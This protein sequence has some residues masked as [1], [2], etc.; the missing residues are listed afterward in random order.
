MKKLVLLFIINCC[1]QISASAQCGQ[2]GIDSGVCYNSTDGLQAIAVD[3][4]I[5]TDIIV[6]DFTAGSIETCCDEIVV[7]SGALGSGTGG[8]Q[9]YNASQ[10]SG[11]F[12]GLSFTAAAP[13]E[14]LSIYVNADGSVDCTTE[15]SI[16]PVYNTSCIGCGL[17]GV[18]SGVCYNSTDGLQAIAV[19]IGS[20]TD[21][22]VVDF[23]AGS[24]ETCC[25]EI[26]VYSG[27]LGSGT[28]GTQ[29]HNASQGSGTFAGL[30]FT[31]AAPGEYLSIY[32]NADGSVDCTT[33]G[34]ISPVYNTSC[35]IPSIGCGLTGVDS[36]VCYN[37]TD[38]LQPIAINIG[39]STD[40]ITVNFTA[41]SIETCCDE[42][43]VY[44]GPLGSGTGGTQ[45]HNASQASGTFAGLSFTA[46]APGEY[47][48]I[49]VN[50][51]GSVDCTTEG[52]VSPVYNT[53]CPTL[54]ID[55]V[56]FDTSSLTIYPNP[57]SNFVTLKNP[58]NIKLKNISIHDLTGRLVKTLDAT[59]VTD[60]L[61]IDLS[62]LSSNIYFLS[63]ETE[64]NKITFK[65]IKE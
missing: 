14:Y 16:S 15:G 17:T 21:I 27:P 31:A 35:I 64:K 20:P 62:D 63:A 34:N 2:T 58:E 24:I 11:T 7:Y 25:D 26:V 33:E 55:T 54:G 28:G 37:S 1:F 46:A 53:S 65:V 52:S 32:V 29:I 12:A 30:S 23:T 8:T 44:S 5:P 56:R 57:T 9:I 22:I 19:D 13:G 3:I 6:V 40:I 36:G 10:G 60:K 61:Q 39:I 43:V 42:I 38:G 4:G 50:A 45:I 59:N 47:L 49:Y 18:D 48:S 41:G 51:D